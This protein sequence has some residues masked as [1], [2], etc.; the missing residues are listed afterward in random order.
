MT[1]LVFKVFYHH[2]FVV[3]YL[4]YDVFR[5]S[6]S[7]EDDEP[8]KSKKVSACLINNWGYAIVHQGVDGKY[9]WV[10]HSCKRAHH[11]NSSPHS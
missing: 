11:S 7:G 8:T 4:L 5:L 10:P 9:S 1:C 2:R 6:Q 3:L